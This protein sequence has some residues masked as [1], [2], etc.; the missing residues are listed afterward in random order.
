MGAA[1]RSWRECVLTQQSSRE[2][3]QRGMRHML[4]R[5]LSLAFATW[6]SEA[7][8]AAASRQANLLAI[9]GA[10]ETARRWNLCFLSLPNLVIC[11]TQATQ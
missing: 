9:L 5:T 1:W 8:A 11:Y 7:T 6:L 10:K 2:Q 4:Q 3:M